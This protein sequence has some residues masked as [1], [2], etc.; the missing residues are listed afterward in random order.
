MDKAS[1]LVLG[2]AQVLFMEALTEVL[3]GAGHQVT[4]VSTRSDLVDALRTGNPQLCLVDNRFPDGAIV[5]ILDRLVRANTG[6]RF[7]IVTADEDPD[8]LLAALDAGAMGYVHKTRGISVLLD[9]VHR[10]KLG[11]TVIEGT[12]VRSRRPTQRGSAQVRRLANYLTQR[13]LECLTLLVAGLD[14]VA[15]SRQLGVS[16]TTV[17]S[18]VQAVL[19]K[20]G[21]HS[22]LEAASL[23]IRY[24]LVDASPR[25]EDPDVTQEPV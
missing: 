23:A 16:R 12:F 20:L 22:R 3:A 13:E 4:G 11:E 18:H 10:V 2:D 17:R 6:C 8:L 9:A 7:I 24:G 1:H 15:M 19:T 25:S 14:T 5:D 21:V